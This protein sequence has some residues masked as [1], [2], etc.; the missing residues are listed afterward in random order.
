MIGEKRDHLPSLLLLPGP[1]EPASRASLSA[2][3]R[4]PL[5]MALARTKRTDKAATLIVAV[6][7]SWLDGP[8]QET[9]E[10]VWPDMSALLAGLYTIIA[11]LCAKMDIAT[12]MDGGPGSVDVRVVLLDHDRSRAFPD[13]LP[14]IE[15]NNTI[16][17]DLPSFAA[18]Y[19][20]WNDIFHVQS[21]AG[22]HLNNLYVK[23]AQTVQ[24]IADDQLVAVAGGLTMHLGPSATASGTSTPA[25]RI[26]HLP[27]P[28]HACV[29]LGGTF[30][31]LHPGHKLLLTAGAL[32][33]RVPTPLSGPACEYVIG[34]TGD[35]MLRNKRYA[36]YVQPWDERARN[37]IYFLASL[38]ELA[39][40]GWEEKIG[41][42]IDEHTAGDFRASF[43]NGSIT[44][45][46]VRID[47]AYG[48]TTR[49]PDIGCLVVSG[50]TRSGGRAVNQERAKL[51]WQLVDVFE[52][53]V[54]TADEVATDMAAEDATAT[55]ASFEAKI[56]ST[57][58]R[59]VKAE[60]AAKAKLTEEGKQAST[61]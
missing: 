3:Y 12:D 36:A 57:E 11:V 30:D 2:A 42:D 54:L 37:V 9:K 20:P 16:V 28:S 5:E 15:P 21:E 50:E 31:H 33:L 10:L 29:C 13:F 53:D 43:R 23:F 40:D 25:S 52:V 35:D 59:R 7:A 4:P 44:V 38:L 22:L 32:L 8:S 34:I 24:R 61:S 60:A 17:V 49:R 1:P 45:Q 6:A 19:H 58:I 47:D 51:G 48:P 26:M 18:A 14:I 39:R 56:S 46:C 55:T 27:T 41:P